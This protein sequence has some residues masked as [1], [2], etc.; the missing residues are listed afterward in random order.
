MDLTNSKVKVSS[1]NYNKDHG[2]KSE[3]SFDINFV[4][5]KYYNIK[6]LNFL[7]HETKIKLSNIKLNKNYT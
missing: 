5:R 2:K 3:I 1:L 7:E 4:L 6:N